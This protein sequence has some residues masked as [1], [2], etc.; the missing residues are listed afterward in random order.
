MHRQKV[1][2]NTEV[3][4]SLQNFVLH[5]TIFLVKKG[6]AEEATDEQQPWGLLC[7]LCD[8]GEEKND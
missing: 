7:N 2:G 3:N 6:P 5:V 8:E 4:R 1:P